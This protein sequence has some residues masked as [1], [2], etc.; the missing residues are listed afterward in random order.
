MLQ[1]SFG[2]NCCTWIF[3]AKALESI[4][5]IGLSTL[6]KQFQVYYQNK[7]KTCLRF[8]YCQGPL[9]FFLF[10]FDIILFMLLFNSSPL[11]YLLVFSFC[12]T[13]MATQKKEC[14]WK[15]FG[16]CWNKLF[17][18]FEILRKNNFFVLTGLRLSLSS[19]RNVLSRSTW[20]T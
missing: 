7:G 16:I 10:L 2:E 11:F 13:K 6:Q 17:F 15:I 1:P 5:N 4:L 8:L 19:G 3:I 18:F 12:F 20:T 9:F 14:S